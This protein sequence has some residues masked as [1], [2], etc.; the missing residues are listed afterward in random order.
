MKEDLSTQDEQVS[1]RSFVK[2]TVGGMCLAYATAIGYP[3]FRYLN[4]PVEKSIELSSVKEVSLKGAD[5]LP[6]GSVML[7]KFG[8]HPAMLI[9][10]DNGQWVALDAVCTHLGCTVQYHPELKKIVCACHGGQYDSYTGQNI[11]GPPPR[12]LT[13]YVVHMEA[14]SVTVSR[15]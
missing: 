14:G 9:H 6:A 5:T 11:A 3:V 12:P 4:S 10:H 7:F 15:V 2:V 13:K 8:S 1:R